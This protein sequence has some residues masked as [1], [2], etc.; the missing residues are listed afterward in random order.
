MKNRLAEHCQKQ[1]EPEDA[2][3]RSFLNTLE[4]VE[5]HSEYWHRSYRWWI[6]NGRMRKEPAPSCGSPRN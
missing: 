5:E 2:E 3:V 1:E 6:E 4:Q